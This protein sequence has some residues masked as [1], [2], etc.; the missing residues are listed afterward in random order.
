MKILGVS[1]FM[2][3]ITTIVKAFYSLLQRDDLLL[4]VPPAV[5]GIALSSFLRTWATLA[6][7]NPFTVKKKTKQQQNK[8][9]KTQTQRVMDPS[10]KVTAPPGFL[11]S[12]GWD[13]GKKLPCSM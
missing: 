12:K 1:D 7:I 8:T 6:E 13:N 4:R 2:L 11:R 10:W 9:K 3:T 5:Q